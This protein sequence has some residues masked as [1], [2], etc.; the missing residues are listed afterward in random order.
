MLTVDLEGMLFG[1]GS[2]SWT[3]Q[4]ADSYFGTLRG[5]C[6]GSGVRSSELG[7]KT[8][9]YKGYKKKGV[10]GPRVWPGDP[11]AW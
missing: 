3:T 7:Q 9:R 10:K 6:N 5:F 11:A 8:P 4:M 1:C 2:Q